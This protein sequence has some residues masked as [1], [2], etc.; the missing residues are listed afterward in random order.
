MIQQ[1]DDATADGRPCFQGTVALRRGDDAVVLEYS[2]P[3]GAASEE[4]FGSLVRS[5][6]VSGS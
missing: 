5:L 4:R 1:G 3:R 6:R 2:G